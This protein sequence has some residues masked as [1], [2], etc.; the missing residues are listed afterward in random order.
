MRAEEGA[1]IDDLRRER[2]MMRQ[3]NSRPCRK[4]GLKGRRERKDY[5]GKHDDISIT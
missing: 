2:D 1:D 5:T 4:Y 3:R